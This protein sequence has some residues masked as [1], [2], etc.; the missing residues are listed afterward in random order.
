MNE[1]TLT[2]WL[3]TTALAMIFVSGQVLAV[4]GF[5]LAQ[6]NGCFICHQATSKRVGPAFSDIAKKYAGEANAVALLAAHIV[7]GTGPTGFGW[8]AEGRAELP[9]M[10]P[11]TGVTPENGL[12]LAKWILT[13][14]SKPTDN[15]KFVTSKISVTGQVK[16]PL[17]LNVDD[18]QK[19][20]VLQMKM[21]VRGHLPNEKPTTVIIK[22]VMLR[23]VLEKAA[24]QTASPFDVKKSVIIVS[25]SDG[26]RVVFS[27]PEVL[28]SP[29]GEGAILFFE[30][31]GKPL[32][33]D[34]GKIALTSLRDN[35]GIRF[36]KWVK[37]IEVRTITD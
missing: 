18:L 2:N 3:K 23:D 28:F 26:Y 22:G 17:E 31:D 7:K 35:G 12:V 32:A 1:S 4:D 30:R 16:Q 29:I 19:L 10:P 36:T 9:F 34:E 20:P 14:A 13:E 6:T 21:V 15:A 27:W 33:D 8:Q 37:S 11:N 5:E 24:L 25:A